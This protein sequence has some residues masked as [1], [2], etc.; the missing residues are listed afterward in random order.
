VEN[1]VRDIEH[2]MAANRI[3][4]NPEKTDLIWIGAKQS[5]LKNPDGWR[6]PHHHI[7]CRSSAWCPTHSKLVTGEACYLTQRQVLL[8][9]E[10]TMPHPLFAR[11]W[12]DR[13]TG[14]CVASRIDYCIG[15][16]AGTAKKATDELQR[17]LNTAAGVVSNR[18]KYDRG[19]T[20]FR[21][22]TFHWL[23]VADRIQVCPSVQCCPSVCLS[24]CPSVTFRYLDH[25]GWNSLK[26][27][28]RPNSL[29]PMCGLTPTRVIWCNGNIPKIRV[30]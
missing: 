20:Q 14:A 3:R 29:R 25:I 13:H 27:T 26:I 12:F 1:C 23:D 22:Q 19:L 8:S 17:V 7:W 18:G 24:I 10:T 6:K 21:R 15:L 11:Q 2:R 5:L 9:A 30:E 16:L 4:L 28:S